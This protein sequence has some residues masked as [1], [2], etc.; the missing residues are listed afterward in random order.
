MG[1]EASGEKAR[2]HSSQI[3]RRYPASGLRNVSSALAWVYF[4]V[5]RPN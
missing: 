4:E 5:T 3:V 1:S 2:D